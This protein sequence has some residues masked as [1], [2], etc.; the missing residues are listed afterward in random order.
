MGNLFIRVIL[1][2]H[3]DTDISEIDEHIPL[4]VK[5]QLV[6]LKLIF[7]QKLR[8]IQDSCKNMRILHRQGLIEYDVVEFQARHL[9]DA[10]KLYS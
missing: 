2:T 8:H 3:I 10:V 1:R 7:L 5:I 6:R 4:M 9:R